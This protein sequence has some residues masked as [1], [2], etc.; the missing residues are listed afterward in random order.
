MI[1]SIQYLRGIAALLG[2]AAHFQ[3]PLISHFCGAIGVD[4]FSL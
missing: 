3:I 1:V 2:I 4:I